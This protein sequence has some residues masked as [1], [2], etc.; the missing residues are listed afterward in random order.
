MQKFEGMSKEDIVMNEKIDFVIMWVDGNDPAWQKQKQET[1]AID[2]EEEIDARPQRYRDWDNLKYWFRGVEKNA[3]WVNK[4][5]F[6]TWGH[7][8][9]WL[10]TNNPKVVIVNHN[11]FMPKEGLPC[12]NAN[13]L[14]LNLHRIKGLSEHFVYFNDDMFIIKKVRKEDFFKNGLPVDNAVLNVHCYSEA[15]Q[16]HF[17]Y[18]QAMGVLNKYFDFKKV[19][20]SNFWKWFSPRNGISKNMRTAVLAS[21]PRFPGIWQHHAP[22]TMLKSTYNTIWEKEPEKM[23][24]TT[25][26]HFRN[27]LDLTAATMKAW[28]L[29]SGNFEPR[30]VHMSRSYMIQNGQNTAEEV[31][32]AIAEQK[33]KLITVN[34]GDL[35]EEQFE[36]GKKAVISAFEKIFPEKS[37]FEI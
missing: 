14:E 4:I 37:T 26:H 8:P 18:E 28:Q 23:W 34:D 31:A 10:D 6:V 20:K 5:Y 2:T 19:I 13:P 36:N 25:R 7:V 32:Q 21:C 3:P 17:G 35:T 16:W 15:V 1:L 29:A 9:K 33:Y 22:F 12:F 30:D 24:E 27:K 11:D